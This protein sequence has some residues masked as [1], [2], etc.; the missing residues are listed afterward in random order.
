ML[1]LVNLQ[2]SPAQMKLK[3]FQMI[4]ID[5]IGCKN[6]SY[7]KL[8]HINQ[9]RFNNTFSNF[10]DVCNVFKNISKSYL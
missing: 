10:I 3:N 2:I 7:I 9:I 4:C 8:S 1:R 5:K 6:A